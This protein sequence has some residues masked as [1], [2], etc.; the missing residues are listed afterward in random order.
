MYS[1]KLEATD[2]LPIG[3]REC[4]ALRV[5]IEKL[6]KQQMMYGKYSDTSYTVIDLVER[7]VGMKTGVR[8]ST[9]AG[10]KTV[11]N[12]LKREEFGSRKICDI[13]ISDAKL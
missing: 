8:K 12:I 7:Y 13:R 4:T 3:K 11:V 6:K 10:Y 5:Q 2:K 1:W 9:Q